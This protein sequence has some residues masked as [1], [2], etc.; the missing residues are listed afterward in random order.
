[1]AGSAKKIPTLDLKLA[2]AATY[3]EWTIAIQAHLDLIPIENTKYRIWDIVD[4]KYQE[5]SQAGEKETEEVAASTNKAIGNW[6]DVNSIA[7]L[8]IRRNCEDDVRARIGSLTNAKDAYNELRKG[9]EGK[10]ATEFYTLLDSL[11]TMYDDRKNI[12]EEHIAS[13]EHIWNTF[14]GITTRADLTNDDG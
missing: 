13:Y 14:V 10:T 1:M 9:F 5:P 4:G 8:T 6:K 11:T 2:G 7:L 3:P 12:I